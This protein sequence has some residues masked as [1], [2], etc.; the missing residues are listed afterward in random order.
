MGAGQVRVN[1]VVC[2]SLCTRGTQESYVL[3]SHQRGDVANRSLRDCCSDTGHSVTGHWCLVVDTVLLQCD[4]VSFVDES[5][6]KDFGT[7]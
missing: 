7:V 5:R 2:E 4:A 1:L 6:C 3:G